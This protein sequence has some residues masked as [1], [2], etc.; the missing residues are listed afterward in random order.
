MA[1]AA[2]ADLDTAPFARAEAGRLEEERLAA[3]ESRA[4]ARLACGQAP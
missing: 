4:E 2:F 3:L 1:R